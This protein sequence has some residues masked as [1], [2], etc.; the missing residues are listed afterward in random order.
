[1]DDS[2]GFLIMG[3]ILGG[4]VVFTICVFVALGGG[5]DYHGIQTI[6]VVD[7]YPVNSGFSIITCDQVYY[8]SDPLVFTKIVENGTYKVKFTNNPVVHY[9]I[10]TDLISGDIAPTG[11]S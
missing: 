8:T 5:M 3:A 10:I 4:L 11:C 2:L 1:M 9:F 6:H 7:K